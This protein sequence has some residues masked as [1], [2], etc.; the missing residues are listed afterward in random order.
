MVG[1][2]GELQA[3]PAGIA[4]TPGKT[5]VDP[6]LVAD[7]DHGV[8]VGGGCRARH[9]GKSCRGNQGLT[10]GNGR[11]HDFLLREV[12]PLLFL[13]VVSVD[14]LVM[15]Q[16]RSLCDYYYQCMYQSEAMP[17]ALSIRRAYAARI[18]RMRG[19]CS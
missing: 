17:A 10:A 15:P 11:C 12:A 5:D 6:S 9:H 3:F 2:W 14:G 13:M 7:A 4:P 1:A 19:R 16:K 18:S 8:A